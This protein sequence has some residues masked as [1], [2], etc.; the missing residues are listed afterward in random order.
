MPGEAKNILVFPDTTCTN[1]ALIGERVK[2]YQAPVPTT[3]WVT[4]TGHRAI[5]YLLHGARYRMSSEEYK[6][7]EREH[8]RRF[9]KNWLKYKLSFS[10]PS[11]LR[12]SIACGITSVGLFTAKS[13]ASE[14]I[15]AS[16]GIFAKVCALM[17]VWGWAILLGASALWLVRNIY[18]KCKK[19]DAFYPSS[20]EN[21]KEGVSVRY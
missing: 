2:A 7:Q 15:A 6:Q 12:P 19:D 8:S 18:N 11:T 10:S 17:P 1:L 9:V 21:K 14:G 20:V 13:V 16:W 5:Q 4:E 3:E